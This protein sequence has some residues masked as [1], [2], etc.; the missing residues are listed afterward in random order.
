MH[1]CEPP[2][3]DGS[4]ENTHPHPSPLPKGEGITLPFKGTF[5]VANQGVLDPEREGITLPFK[6][7]DRVGMGLS[8]EI[9]IFST[10]HQSIKSPGKSIIISATSSDGVIEAIELPNY[11]FLIGVQWHPEREPE[12]I[13]TRLLFNTFVAAALKVSTGI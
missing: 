8:S 1:L 6:G 12:S 11:P 5:Q 4:S 9:S 3:H 7:R 13:H 2:A 10:H